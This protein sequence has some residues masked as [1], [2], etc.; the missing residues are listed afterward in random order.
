VLPKN[1][2]WLEIETSRTGVISVKIDRRRK[3]AITSLLRIFGLTTNDAILAA[4]KEVDTNSETSYIESTLARDPSSNYDE[5]CLEVY[6]KMRPGEP[7]VLDNAKSL[8]HSMFFNPRRYSLGKVGRFKI[9]QKLGSEIPNDNKH[10]LLFQED[11]I[12]IVTRI[13]GINNGSYESDDIDH[14]GNRRVKSVGEL[15]QN[16]I[17]IGFLQLE[18]NIK[19]RMSL[20]PTGEKH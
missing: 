1:G 18:R 6:K 16:Q 5:A 4:F 2:V 19:E 15:L 12:N 13:V 10:W 8:V 11:L 20:H 9:N 17:R 3:L 7:L 14:L